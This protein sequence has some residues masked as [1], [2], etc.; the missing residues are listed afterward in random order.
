MGIYNSL[1]SSISLTCLR[2]AREEP[3]LLRAAAHREARAENPASSPASSQPPHPRPWYIAPLPCRLSRSLCQ[4]ACQEYAFPPARVVAHW[5]LCSVSFLA[6]P[7]AR[8]ILPSRCISPFVV[9]LRG[10]PGHGRVMG[11]G[12]WVCL[13]SCIRSPFL[14][15]DV[16]SDLL[17]R[18]T[19]PSG[20]T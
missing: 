2:S 5:T 19:V 4:T 3:H 13:R 15:T 1:P 9:L 12:S 11:H 6:Q 10:I 18:D 20:T 14:D 17:I 8:E 16:A 7:Q